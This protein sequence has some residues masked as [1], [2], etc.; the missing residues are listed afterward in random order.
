MGLRAVDSSAKPDRA[1]RKSSGGRPAGP[2]DV[3]TCPRDFDAVSKTLWKRTRELLKRDNAWRPEYSPLLERYVRA[4]EVGRLA[5]GRITER[6]KVDP[7]SA[8]LTTGSQGQLVQHPDLKTA[9]EAERDANEYA[10]ELLLTRSARQK[11][12]E[13]AAPAVG[14][15]FGG[16]FG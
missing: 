15:K 14:G 10:R 5:R 16:A 11:L 6:A 1:G 3:S 4:I 2:A 9:R 7:E 8:Y 12:G 13:E